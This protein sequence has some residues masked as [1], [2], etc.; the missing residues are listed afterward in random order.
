MAPAP[1]RGLLRRTAARL[2]AAASRDER[3]W[4]T[5]WRGPTRSAAEGRLT[6]PSLQKER[7]R[8]ACSGACSA[9]VDDIG[10]AEPR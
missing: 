6:R 1:Y 9:A 4:A 10:C 7:A 8:L 3:S 2:R 5:T